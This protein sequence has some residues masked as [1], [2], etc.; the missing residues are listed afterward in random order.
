MILPDPIDAKVLARES[1]ALETGFLQEPDRGHICRNTRGFD[2]MKLQSPECERNDG[3]SPRPSY[4]LG[5]R[6]AASIQVAEAARLG[7]AATNIGERQSAHEDVPPSRLRK[8]KK[9]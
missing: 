8:I 4:D 6:R 5:A 2:A 9:A 1:L 7:T 3:S